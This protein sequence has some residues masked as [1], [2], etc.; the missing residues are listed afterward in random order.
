STLAK[1]ESRNCSEVTI[2]V[3][4]VHKVRK[5][6]FRFAANHQVNEW[7]GLH[8]G[9]VHHRCLRPT[10]CDH[11]F[12]MQPLDFRGNA[13]GKRVAA[14]YRTEAKEIG[15]GRSKA[16]SGKAAEIA[17]FPIQML[18]TFVIDAIQVD[19]FR[20]EALGFQDSG[21]AQDTDRG[22]LAHDASR[23]RFAHRPVE[24]VG[25][26]RTDQADVHRCHRWTVGSTVKVT[27]AE[28]SRPPVHR[29]QLRGRG[30]AA[31]VSN[32]SVLEGLP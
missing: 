27:P 25:R 10:Q 26:G 5:G 23:V 2:A 17:F 14:A 8:S 24:L 16:R 15:F 28:Y 21:E 7:I 22:K 3:Q 32:E 12:W 31:H 4:S 6:L 1:G 20:L 30:L 9:D 29:A 18:P 13:K 11:R 19:D